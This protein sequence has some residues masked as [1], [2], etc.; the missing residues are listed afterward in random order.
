MQ[1][2]NITGRRWVHQKFKI[3]VKAKGSGKNE[4]IIYKVC[5]KNVSRTQYSGRMSN[6]KN[7]AVILL[8]GTFTRLLFTRLFL[9]SFFILLSTFFPFKS[10]FK[11]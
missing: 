7:P 1:V 6:L 10:S 8:S 3:G 4:V 11:G 9:F 5:L 2:K